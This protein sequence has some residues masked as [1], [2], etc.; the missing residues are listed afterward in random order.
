MDHGGTVTVEQ[1]ARAWPWRAGVALLGLA[2]IALAA[3]WG[4]EDIGTAIADGSALLT[5]AVATALLWR[6]ARRTTG[7][8]RLPWLLLATAAALWATGELIWTWIEV[9]Q[10]REV[11]FP[12]VADIAYL[13]ATPFA[14]LGLVAFSARDGRWFQVRHLVDS[15]L[16]AAAALFVTWALVLGPMVRTGGDDL[17]SNVISIAYPVTDLVL[18]V[19]ALL[20]VRWSGAGDRRALHVVA[21]ALVVMGITDSAFTWMMNQG[22]FSVTHPITMLWPASYLLLAYASTLTG[23]D[24]DESG[25]DLEPLGA[26]LTP[27]VLVVAV[28]AV[29]TPRV[30]EGRSLGPFLTVVGSVILALLLGRQVLT[31]LDLRRTVQVLHE[32]ERELD[33]LAHQDALTGLANRARLTRHLEA[34]VGRTGVAPSVVYIDLDGFK[35]VNDHF[36]HATGDLLLVEV[37][38]R[39]RACTGEG[40]LLA[41]LGGDE[42][43]VVVQTGHDAALGAARDILR[44][45]ELP[46][47]CQGESIP[48]RA[49]IGVASAPAGGGPE[50]AMRRADAAMYA[51]KANGKGHAVNYP[52]GV[53]ELESLLGEA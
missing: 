38:E 33:R 34:L 24:Q 23:V 11:P 50:E 5:A 25:D 2:T 21:F 27:Y 22:T 32:R 30:L 46:F 41:R 4:G 48:F 35:E 28:A 8:A 31:A 49:S 26:V 10:R 18:A 3:G 1:R 47:R 42:F 19:L 15:F 20:L 39:L 6:R 17:L 36:G 9:V 40:M 16:V 45:F 51:A 37:S 44:A 53:L 43:V 7:R 52:D 14:A 29:A 13:G 12:S